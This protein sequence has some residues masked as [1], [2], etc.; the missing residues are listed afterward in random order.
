MRGRP[1]YILPVPQCVQYRQALDLQCKS[2]P[3]IE[4]N[5]ESK[6]LKVCQYAERG[7]ARSREAA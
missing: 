2:L 6:F 4:A 1:L 3:Y 7:V 5:K